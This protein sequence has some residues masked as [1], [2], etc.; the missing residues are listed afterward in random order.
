VHMTHMTLLRSCMMQATWHQTSPLMFR[1][2][3]FVAELQGS[4]EGGGRGATAR[5]ASDG[6]GAVADMWSIRP[7]ILEEHGVETERTQGVETERTQSAD[8]A[9]THGS[10]EATSTLGRASANSTSANSSA[11]ST[12]STPLPHPPALP[13][14]YSTHDSNGRDGAVQGTA[15]EELARV[16]QADWLGAPRLSWC[17]PPRSWR[18]CSSSPGKTTRKETSRALVQHHPAAARTWCSTTLLQLLLHQP[19]PPQARRC[20]S[21]TYAPSTRGLCACASRRPGLC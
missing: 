10:P 19:L 15:D 3:H 16:R 18:S 9:M 20:E 12:P 4:L 17:S 13:V 7:D 2:H 21:Y 14:P 1:L 8:G 5:C 6:A 11:N